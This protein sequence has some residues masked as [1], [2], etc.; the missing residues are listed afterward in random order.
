[1]GVGVSSRRPDARTQQIRE[2]SVSDRLRRGFD[3]PPLLLGVLGALALGV[4]LR[5][6]CQSDLWADEVLSVS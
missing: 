2:E 5:F 1:M 6:V 3:S 4:A